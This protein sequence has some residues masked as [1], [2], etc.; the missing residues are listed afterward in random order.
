[1]DLTIRCLKK[2]LLLFKYRQRNVLVTVSK[3]M[4]ASTVGKKGYILGE[5]N[6]WD[7]FYSPK[8]GLTI[9]ALGWVRS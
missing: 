7:Y 6:D 2:S 5:D 3:Q 8:T 9:P 1:M 4:D